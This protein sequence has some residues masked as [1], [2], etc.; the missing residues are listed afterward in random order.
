MYLDRQGAAGSEVTSAVGDDDGRVRKE[1]AEF[2]AKSCGLE[3]L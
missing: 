1:G 2:S 3:N